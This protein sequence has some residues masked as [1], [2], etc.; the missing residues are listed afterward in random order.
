MAVE[1][2][3]RLEIEVERIDAAIKERGFCLI[4]EKQLRLFAE[5][6]KLFPFLADLARDRG[7]SFE[8]HPHDD[9]RILPLFSGQTSRARMDS[10]GMA[11]S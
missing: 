2:N 8:F 11:S 7:W 9:V 1:P 6:R 5:E 10:H 3:N 4:E